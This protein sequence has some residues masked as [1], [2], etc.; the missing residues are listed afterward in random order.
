MKKIISKKEL[1]E[2]GFIIGFAFPIL[3]GWFIPLITGHAFKVWTIYLG[4]LGITMGLIAPFM[5]YY[6]FEFCI[7]LR[8]VLVWVS[9][10]ILLALFF[11]LVLLPIALVMRLFG[12]DPLR[13][14]RKRVATYRENKKNYKLNLSSIF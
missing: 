8:Y 4:V 12:Y 10:R 7:K 5:L 9:S 14:R 13:N 6:P 11:I 3:V 1:R 2:F